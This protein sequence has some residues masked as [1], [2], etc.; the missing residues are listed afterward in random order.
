MPKYDRSHSDLIL[1]HRFRWRQGMPGVLLACLL[2]AQTSPLRILQRYHHMDCTHARKSPIEVGDIK[3]RART[4]VM[5]SSF[6][7]GDKGV[8]QRG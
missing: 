7:I 1:V 5:C 6:C 4:R 3:F 8:S 2:S